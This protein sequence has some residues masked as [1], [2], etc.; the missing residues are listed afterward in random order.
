MTQ[1]VLFGGGVW[2]TAAAAIAGGL[3]TAVVVYLLS[4]RDRVSGGTR[5]VLVGIGVGSA[6]SALTSLLMVRASM[7]NASVAQLW[8]SGSLTGRGWPYVLALAVGIL[9]IVP[10]LA[11]I[12]RSVSYLEMGDDAAQS[13]GIPA[14]RMRLIAM[15]L[16]V[17]LAAI[18][19][20]AAGPIAFIAFAAPHI[21]RRIRPSTGVQL[22][23]SALTGALLLVLAD[24]LSANLDVGLRTPAGLVTSLLGGVYLLWLLARRI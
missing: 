9:L 15:M 4:R 2:Q 22:G 5:L 12:S 6:L 21:A 24:L 3:T 8:T 19:V 20:A 7:D 11:V 14:E 23:V 18:A 13:L 16:A 1:I 17:M 10:A